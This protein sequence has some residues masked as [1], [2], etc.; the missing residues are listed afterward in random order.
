[1]IQAHFIYCA[2]YF[3]Y[4]YISPTCD[5]QALGPRGRGTPGLK[6][7]A[8]QPASTSSLL[9]PRNNR[10]DKRVTK[11]SPPRVSGGPNC[12]PRK[13][14]YKATRLSLPL[15]FSSSLAEI[16]TISS[17]LP[18]WWCL[19][20]CLLFLGFLKTGPQWGKGEEAS[21]P[22]ISLSGAPTL[23]LPHS[24]EDRQRTSRWVVGGGGHFLCKARSLGCSERNPQLSWVWLH[25]LSKNSLWTGQELDLGTSGWTG[26]GF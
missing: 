21:P 10:S 8:S 4:D 6:E 17:S 1:M 19:E 11:C 13:T 7:A 9:Q 2:L 18:G 20:R 25:L 23:N 26:K 24:W 22:D 12:W 15:T 5:H 14:S 3:Y 16:L